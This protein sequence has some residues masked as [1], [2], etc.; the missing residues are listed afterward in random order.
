MIKVE[1]I[2]HDIKNKNAAFS[3]RKGTVKGKGMRLRNEHST[4]NRWYLPKHK[5]MTAYHYALQYQEWKNEY[6]TMSD[7]SKAIRYDI[8]HVQETGDSN[9]TEDIAVKRAEIKKRMDDLKEIAIEAAGVELA[10]FILI[11]ATQ[12]GASYTYLHTSLGMPCS[13][14]TYSDRRGKFYYKLSGYLEKK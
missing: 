7:T 11:G 8:D 4:R 14:N 10:D 6:K 2:L 13:R 1:T 5:F 3:Q 9:P 12:E